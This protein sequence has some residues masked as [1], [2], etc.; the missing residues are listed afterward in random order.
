VSRLT[1]FLRRHFIWAGF[2]AV[3][4]PLLVLLGLQYIWLVRLE[5]TST[6]AHQAT[7]MNYLEAVATELQYFYKSNAERALN[8]PP[9]VFT[10]NRID[11]AAWYF[12]KKEIL[13]ARRLFVYSF[14]EE[15]KYEPLFFFNPD[16]ASMERAPFEDE[17]RAIFVACSPWRLIAMK[18]GLVHSVDIEVDERDPNNRIILN[19]IND[20]GSKVVGV[21]GEILDEGYLRAE[22]LPVAVSKSLP[23]FFSA[24][25]QEDLI[26]NVRDGK[27]EIL[28]ATMNCKGAKDDAIRAVPFVFTDWKLGLRSA[29]MT[30]EQWARSN[31]AL[32]VTLSVLLAAVLLCGLG[33]ALRTASRAVKLSQMKSDFVSNVS[34][35]LRTPI[36]SIRVFGEFLKLGRVQD[37]EKAREYGEYIEAEGRR[38]T[39]LIDNILDFS[40]IESGRKLY[41]FENADVKE[42]VADA[43]RTFEVR[44]RH[45]GTAIRYECPETPVP[46]ARVDAAAIS[47]AVTNLLDNAHKYSNGAKEITVRLKRDNGYVV[48]AVADH[49]IG[50]SKDEQKK[51]FERFHRVSTG[52]VHDVKGSGL[53][54]SIVNHI[55]RAHHGIVAVESEPGRGSTF[56]IRLPVGEEGNGALA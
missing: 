24:A 38:L 28:Y 21:V 50:I 46:P 2:L 15:H 10:Q 20:E 31:F 37:A 54:L 25:D 43:V 5:K 33:L 35:E 30:P 11:K 22:V 49:G 13:G 26:V 44:L 29:R 56:S 4:A 48:I 55:V 17:A 23:K 36:A 40:K 32:N 34:H 6:L 8:I 16:T 53:G 12:K 9:S 19:P 14:M 41:N 39:Q 18:G 51:I 1:V 45:G 47:Q 3:L 42:I 52:L 27:G 7:L